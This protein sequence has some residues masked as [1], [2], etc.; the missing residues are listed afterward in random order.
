MDLK[1][2]LENDLALAL[3]IEKRHACK[4]SIQNGRELI[5]RIKDVLEPEMEI[6][7]AESLD[8]SL[9]SSVSVGS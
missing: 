8:E 6:S 1:N 7:N 9:L 4:I 2:E 3:L 5:G